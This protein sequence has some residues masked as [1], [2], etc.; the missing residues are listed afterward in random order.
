MIGMIAGTVSRAMGHNHPAACDVASCSDVLSFCEDHTEKHSGCCPSESKESQSSDDSDQ[1]G[2]RNSDHHHHHICCVIPSLIANDDKLVGLIGC[3][4]IFA[5][6][7]LE[8]H[9]APESPVFELDT[10]PLI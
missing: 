8:H 6:L 10:P 1:E 2:Q 4:A 3:G 5:E 9:S 7:N